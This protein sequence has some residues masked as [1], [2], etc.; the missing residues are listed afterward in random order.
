MLNK[1]FITLVFLISWFHFGI[2]QQ[3][4]CFQQ[5]PIE[6]I[7]L[8]LDKHYALSGDSIWFDAHCLQANQE[9]SPLSKVLY[10]E[11]FNDRQKVITQHKFKINNGTAWGVIPIPESVETGYYFLRAYT[12]YM[13]N[14]SIADFYHQNLILVNPTLPPIKYVEVKQVDSQVNGS[15]VASNENSPTENIVIN[16][17]QKSYEPRQNIQFQIALPPQINTRANV[18]VAVRKKGLG[19]S[20]FLAQAAVSLKKEPDSLQFMPEIK[21]TS[22]SG[23]LTNKNTQTPAINVLCMATSIEKNPQLYFTYS[24]ADGTFI[25]DLGEQEG[26]KQFFITARNS[27]KTDLELQLYQDFDPQ[28]PKIYPIPLDLDSAQ[29]QLIEGLYLEQEIKKNYASVKQKAVF[30]PKREPSYHPVFSNPDVRIILSDYINIPNLAEVF[31][32]IIPNVSLK[33]VENK[34]RLSVYNAKEIRQMNEPLVLLD[35]ALVDDIDKMLEIKSEKIKSIEVFTLPYVIGRHKMEGIILINTWTD[36]F[37][38]Y[39]WGD[40]SVFLRYQTVVDSPIF[41]QSM[42]APEDARIP[43]FRNVLYWQPNVEL[44]TEAKNIEFLSSDRVGEYEVVVSGWTTDGKPCKIQ[45]FFRV[46]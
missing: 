33:K 25:F 21:N 45:Q 26:E 40:E 9:P 36:D 39:E 34:S 22:L 11:I 16:G 32:E 10:I 38:G 17:L 18:S 19:G 37:A 42:Y 14:F 27:D 23:K 28:L 2:S 6:K 20:P 13:R 1:F 35:Y 15:L 3:Q 8:Q 43:D 12:Q 44:G 7:S 5:F 46:E 31:T 24:K 29:Q 41:T 4:N 30:P